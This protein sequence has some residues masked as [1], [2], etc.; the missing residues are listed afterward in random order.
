MSRRVGLA[1]RQ[2]RGS[3]T[4]RRRRPIQLD[5]SP[6]G[7]VPHQAASSDPFTTGVRMLIQL[8]KLRAE[9][10][11]HLRSPYKATISRLLPGV[12]FHRDIASMTCDASVR[13]A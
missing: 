13:A 4:I 11:I 5:S 3:T 9:G 10:K 8:K 2:V 6:V 1:A 7:Y 12:M